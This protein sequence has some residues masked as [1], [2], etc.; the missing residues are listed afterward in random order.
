MLFTIMC[1]YISWAT[2]ACYSILC[3]PLGKIAALNPIMVLIKTITTGEYLMERCEIAFIQ[4]RPDLTF[5]AAL[6]GQ[7]QSEKLCT[8]KTTR[9]CDFQLTTSPLHS[10]R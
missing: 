2:F 8:E 5:A 9:G 7:M 1:F 10:T 6:R 3:F 4:V